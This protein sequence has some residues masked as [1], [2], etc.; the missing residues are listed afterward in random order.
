MSTVHVTA[1]EQKSGGYQIID[2]QS[3]RIYGTVVSWGDA[4]ALVKESYNDVGLTVVVTELPLVA[5]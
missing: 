4:D 5:Q 1:K 3:D 2:D